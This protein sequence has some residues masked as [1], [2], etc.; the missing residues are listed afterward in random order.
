MH[1]IDS[2]MSPYKKDSELSYINNNAAK[3]PLKISSELYHLINKSI[4]ISKLSDGAFDITFSSVG[5]FY[6]YRKNLNQ[7]KKNYPRI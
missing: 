1:R 2:L 5:Q 3:H 4:Q 7:Q 6:D